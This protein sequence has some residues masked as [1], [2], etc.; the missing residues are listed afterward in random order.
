MIWNS[1]PLKGKA[2]RFLRI[3]LLRTNMSPVLLPV[4]KFNWYLPLKYL[5]PEMESCKGKWNLVLLQLNLL[6]TT[7]ESK[8]SP[9]DIV[10]TISYPF[11]F[12]LTCYRIQSPAHRFTSPE[13][14]FYS[15][16]GQTS[17]W[18][19]VQCRQTKMPES[20]PPSVWG[21]MLH[22]PGMDLK[23]AGDIKTRWQEYT[24]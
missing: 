6:K 16:C 13:H 18:L 19:S 4:G 23:E 8:Y 3:T 24:E 2:A 22:M 15:N 20:G 12:F 7:V 5:C 1:T 11:N 14:A 21:G 10:H 9:R 17:Q